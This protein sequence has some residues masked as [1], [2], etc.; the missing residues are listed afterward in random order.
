MRP[1]SVN[2][3]LLGPFG[4]PASSTESD[5]E[6]F[7]ALRLAS[8]KRFIG[9]PDSGHQHFIEENQRYL[10]RPFTDRFTISAEDL[11]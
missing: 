7:K 3:P 5:E 2:L 6:E 8:G 4:S 11:V 1:A 10:S 9:T